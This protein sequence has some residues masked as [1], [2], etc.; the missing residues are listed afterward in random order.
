M[1]ASG[2]Q[3]RWGL[4]GRSVCDDAL[5]YWLGPPGYRAAN[6]RT[7]ATALVLLP[8]IV[9]VEVADWLPRSRDDARRKAVER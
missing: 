7:V 3:T 5:T 8:L 6:A 4:W 2:P 9:F 1:T